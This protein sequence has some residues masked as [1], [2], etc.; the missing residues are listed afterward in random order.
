MAQ[1]AS[2]AG[3]IRHAGR[4][5]CGKQSL[6]KHDFLH[7]ASPHMAFHLRKPLFESLPCLSELHGVQEKEFH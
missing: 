1:A 5:T 6:H 4:P 7:I 3:K 2:N